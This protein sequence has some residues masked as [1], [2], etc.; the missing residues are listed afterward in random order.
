MKNITY[1]DSMPYH[2]IPELLGSADVGLC[3]YRN[4]NYEPYGFH[5]SP[6]KL[7]DYLASELVV[8]GSKMGQI[9]E[10]IKDD[11]NGYLVDDDVDNMVRLID[12]ISENPTRAKAVAA[13][14]RKLVTNFYHWDRAADET[15]GLISE[16]I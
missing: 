9:E 8:I 7:Y 1:L 6:L 4:M 16:C 11:R 14:G 2:E 13:E 15:M 10:V 5:L 12:Y 3:L